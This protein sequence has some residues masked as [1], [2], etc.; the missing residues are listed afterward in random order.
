VSKLSRQNKV[1]LIDFDVLSVQLNRKGE[2]GCLVVE[3]DEEVRA[4]TELVKRL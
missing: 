2:S 1:L 4:M 3:P